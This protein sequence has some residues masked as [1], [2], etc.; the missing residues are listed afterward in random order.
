MSKKAILFALGFAVIAA[1]GGSLFGAMYIA[2]RIVSKPSTMSPVG[3]QVPEVE[4]A[5]T[6]PTKPNT[7]INAEVKQIGRAHV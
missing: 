7:F 1:L 2:K 6:T 3:T 5:P 4:T